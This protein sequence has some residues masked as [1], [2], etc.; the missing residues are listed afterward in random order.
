[1]VWDD[2]DGATIRIQITHLPELPAI[3]NES[4]FIDEI[5]ESIKVNCTFENGT[6]LNSTYSQW[7][8]QYFTV[9]FLP[10]G[11]WVWIDALFIDTIQSY[12]DYLPTFYGRITESYFVFGNWYATYDSGYGWESHID[13]TTGIPLSFLYDIDDEICESDYKLTLTLFD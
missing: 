12:G 9:A 5:V 13:M 11:D 6:L 4:Y 2:M 10:I 8:N 1:V 3:I 7:L